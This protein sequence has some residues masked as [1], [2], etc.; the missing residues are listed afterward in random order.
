MRGPLL[1]A[2]M[3]AHCLVGAPACRL[4]PDRAASWQ[5]ALGRQRTTLWTRGPPRRRTGWTTPVAGGCVRALSEGGRGQSWPAAVTPR[6]AIQRQGCR[7]AAA[8][9]SCMRTSAGSHAYSHQLLVHACSRPHVHAC[10]RFPPRFLLH[11][12]VQECRDADA[13]QQREQRSCRGTPGNLAQPEQ[14][15]PHHS[16][17]DEHFA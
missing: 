16:R 2:G 13:R 3:T 9:V 5:P 1:G 4:V 6:A 14:L 17:G 12:L 10:I 11:L 15:E 8:H 7:H